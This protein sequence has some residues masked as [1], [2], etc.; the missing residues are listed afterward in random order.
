MEWPKPKPE[1]M[2]LVCESNTILLVLPVGFSLEGFKDRVY[3][4]YEV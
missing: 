3:G 2:M 4:A 1:S